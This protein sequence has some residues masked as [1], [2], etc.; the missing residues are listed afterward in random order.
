MFA[1]DRLSCLSFHGSMAVLGLKSITMAGVS[2]HISILYLG[3]EC[4]GKARKSTSQTIIQV[5]RQ[6]RR[7]WVSSV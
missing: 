3:D 5:K 4:N 2:Y 7:Q 6:S 1:S